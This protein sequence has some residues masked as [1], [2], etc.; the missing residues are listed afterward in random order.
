MEA[1]LLSCL[2]E[3]EGDAAGDGLGLVKLGVR[4]HVQHLI[5]RRLLPGSDHPAE[6]V[7]LC[8]TMSERLWN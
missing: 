6:Q 5:A 4:A 8:R 3:T 2:R 7:D 1:E